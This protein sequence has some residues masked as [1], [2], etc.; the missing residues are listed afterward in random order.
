MGQSA[1]DTLLDNYLAAI[2]AYQRPKERQDAVGP[3]Y[4]EP[5]QFGRPL[6]HAAWM[7]QEMKTFPDWC[8]KQQRWLGFVQGVLFMEGVFSIDDMRTH[9]REAKERDASLLE[10]PSAA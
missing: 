10:D 7:C 2:E 4:F 5:K 8:G 9:V 1:I 3:A 6:E